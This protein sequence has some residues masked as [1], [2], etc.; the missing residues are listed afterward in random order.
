TLLLLTG[1]GLLLRSFQRLQSVNQGFNTE[2]LLSFDITLPGVKYRTPQLRSRFFQGLMEK[3]RTLPGV[4]ETGMTSRIPLDRKHGDVFP[5]S[6]EGRAKPP[7]SL[8]NTMET[9]IASPEYFRVMGIPLLRGRLFTAR[10]GP[11]IEPVIIV[12]DEFARR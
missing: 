4:E 6:V 3:L 8:Q 1:A 7:E 9:I 12:D 5:F 2:R 11:D 10:D